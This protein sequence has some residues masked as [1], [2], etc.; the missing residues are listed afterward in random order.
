MKNQYFFCLLYLTTTLFSLHAAKE[1][2]A[3]KE[4]KMVGPGVALFIPQGYEASKN[5]SLAFEKPLHPSGPIPENWKLVPHF[6]ATNEKTEVS[7]T[8]PFEASLYGTGEV[9]GP[10]LRNGKKITLWNSDNSTYARKQGRRLYQS[11]PWVLGVRLDGTAFG[12]IFDT[13]WKARLTTTSREII[14]KSDGPPLRVVVIEGKS[15]QEVVRKLAELTG[16]MPLPPKWALGFQQCRYSYYPD[17]KVREIADQYRARHLPCD[18]IWLDIHY[19]DGYRSFTFD[20]HRFPDP[21]ATID[22]LH[23]HGFHS[24]WIIDPGIKV[25]PNYSVYQSGSEKHFWVQKKNGDPFYGV[26]WPGLSAFPDFTIPQVREW[27]SGLYHQFLAYGMDG[28]WND[29]NE[30][31]VFDTP[32]L[33]MPEENWHRGGGELPAGIHRMYHNVYGMLMISATRAGMLLERPQERPFLLTRSNYLGGQRYAAT[34][35]GDNS[36]GMNYLKMSIPMGLN[37]GLSGEP[38]NGVDLGGYAGKENPELFGKWIVMAPFFPFA[39]AHTAVYNPPREPWV[40]GSKIENVTRT[41]L[42][43]RYRLL[44]YL[45]TLFFKAS[46]QGDPIMQPVFFAD[47]KNLLLRKED[48]AFLLGENLLVIPRWARFP[49]LPR[50]MWRDISLLEDHREKDGYQP[51][52]KIRGGSIVPLGRVIQNTNEKSLDPLTLLVCLDEHGEAAGELYEDAGNGFEYQHGDY[53]LTHYMAHRHGKSV[54][55]K[56]LNREGSRSIPNRPIDVCLILNDRVLEKKGVESK[57]VT[58]SLL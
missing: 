58:F 5:P 6:F 11:H 40:F 49:M 31:S 44:P 20:P 34:W 26:V 3:I 43:R 22:Y 16:K 1:E 32:D 4:K 57:G 17:S 37:L 30:P 2:I 21:K 48:R 51:E 23:E 41:A 9:T 13:T 53:A 29:M 47:P 38:F 45:Y 46:S 28:I 42:E 55:V 52:I 54:T 39:R 50:G 7:L 8:I 56:I 33:T 19:M 14:F 27:W 36:S 10:L 25:D 24:V 18:V 12:V 15:P 35:T